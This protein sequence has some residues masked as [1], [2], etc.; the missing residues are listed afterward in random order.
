[1]R[2]RWLLSVLLGSAVSAAAPDAFAQAKGFGDKH[3][4]ILTA[5]RLVPVFS[6]ERT[7]TTFQRGN[8]ATQTD[9]VTRTSTMLLFSSPLERLTVHTVPRVGVD[10]TVIDRLTVGGFVA[11]GLGLGGSNKTEVVT[12]ATRNE[13]SLDAGDG[14]LF[15]IGPR[16]GY[17]LPLADVLALWLRGG[18]SFYAQTNRDYDFDNNNRVRRSLTTTSFSIDLDP[19]LAIVP[20]EHFYFSFGPLLN[21]P[22]AGSRKIERQEG[23]GTTSVT[24]DFSQFHVGINASLGGW[25]NL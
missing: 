23:A 8:N 19:Q 9:S 20:I 13:A 2:N 6:V 10:F 21:I 16:V 1:M 11:F 18:F 4:L 22:V 25:F 3:H 15:G 17:I 7:S 5:D 24:N 14:T 12:G